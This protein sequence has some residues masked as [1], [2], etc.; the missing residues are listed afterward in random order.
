MPLTADNAG[1]RM[2]HFAL[3]G[4]ERDLRSQRG[5]VTMIRVL[6]KQDRGIG[7]EAMWLANFVA[8]RVCTRKKSTPRLERILLPQEGEV[9]GRLLL[10]ER[11]EEAQ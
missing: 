2:V 10:L 11:H 7:S 4:A 3:K 8:N 1:V 9:A 5:K 6:G